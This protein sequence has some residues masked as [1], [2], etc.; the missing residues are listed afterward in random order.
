MS[1]DPVNCPLG[2]ASGVTAT[3]QFCTTPFLANK[4]KSADT[5][6]NYW[7]STV[8]NS[9]NTLRTDSTTLSTS[10]SSNPQ[11]IYVQA[12]FSENYYIQ[13]KITLEILDCKS[14]WDCESCTGSNDDVP[15]AL[16]AFE[17]CTS[18]PPGTEID[19]KLDEEDQNHYRQCTA[20][21]V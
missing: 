16:E 6:A 12:L 20:S 4:C 1:S 3:Y 13:N 14:S 8:S 21:T 2:S 10:S 7:D 19:Y 15:S 11:T 9:L 17:G 5:L 18:C